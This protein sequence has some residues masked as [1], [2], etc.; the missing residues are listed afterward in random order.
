M[1]KVYPSQ[2]PMVKL[3][4][5]L[6]LRNYSRQ[7]VRSY[8]QYNKNFL[9]W[10][11]RSPREVRLEDVKEYLRHLI[12]EGKSTAVAYNALKFY[13]QQILK[14][15]FFVNLHLPKR[16]KKLPVVL[17]RDE[18]LAMLTATMNQ[19]HRRLLAL[20]YGA[21]LRVSEAIHLKIR[22]LD[23]SRQLITVRQGK[24]RKDR[25]TLLPQR[26]TSEL[27]G[28]I[29][30]RQLDE[31]LFCSQRGGSLSTRTAQKIFDQALQ[32]SGVAKAAT[33]HS[34][35]HSF[36]THLLENGVDVRYVQALL[37]HSNSRTTQLYTHVTSP[38]L[39]NIHSPL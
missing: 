6:E 5:E 29:A 26:L 13:Y 11:G 15:K 24:G 3:T 31:Y 27:Q 17:S 28:C 1:D 34:L 14:R 21:G 16:A 8:V 4:N 37:G 36:A 18:V 38:G 2:D 32:R 19:K 7:T 10:S 22:D 30:G 25:I 35:R 12:D 39:K 9:R 23:F 20:S 33:F